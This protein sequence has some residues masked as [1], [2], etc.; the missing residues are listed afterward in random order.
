MMQ[1]DAFGSS[2]TGNVREENQDAI[3]AH[4]SEADFGF[5]YAVADGM[6][7][8]EHG[9]IAS[10]L[11]LETFVATYSALTGN[12]PAAKLKRAVQDAN[13]RVNQEATR[14]NARMGTTLTAVHLAG[15]TVRIAHVGDS[16]AYLFRNGKLLL[17]TN[18][19][20]SVGEMVRAKLLSPDKVRQH[21]NRSALSRCLGMELFIQPEISAYT[22]Q[23]GDTLL[24]CSDG[25]WSSLEDDQL[26]QLACTGENAQTAVDTLI[27]AA[28]AN[29]SDDNLSAWVI[30]VQEAPEPAIEKN[31]RWFGLPGLLKHGKGNAAL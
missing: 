26:M 16:R 8:Y 4:I 7:G 22:I 15:N 25:L 19:H 14:L 27:E 2:Q 28:L 11:A 31:R 23:Q 24:V 12:D 9:G 5:L 18:D 1:I 10:A 30:R 29:G 13:L 3:H 17:L 21:Y 6:G 20:T